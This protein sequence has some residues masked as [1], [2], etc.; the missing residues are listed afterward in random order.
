MSL[1]VFWCV[2]TLHWETLLHSTDFVN[3]RGT[4]H[5]YRAA[6]HAKRFDVTFGDGNNDE[7]ND[8][9]D[10]IGSCV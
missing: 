9:E 2:K 8:D 4:H 10:A 3:G 5:L 7:D 1:C 6:G